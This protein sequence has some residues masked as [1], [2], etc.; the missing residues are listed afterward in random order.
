[1][2]QKLLDHITWIR[3]NLS[4]LADD[5]ISDTDWIKRREVGGAAG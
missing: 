3:D 1:M 2:E 5:S 4:L